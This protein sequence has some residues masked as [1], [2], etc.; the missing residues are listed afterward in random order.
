MK[1]FVAFLLLCQGLVFVAAQES[2]DAQ[3][4]INV[5]MHCGIA[6]GICFAILTSCAVSVNVIN[7]RCVKKM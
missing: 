3:Q 5:L 2:I 1:T 4:G 7:K 6:L